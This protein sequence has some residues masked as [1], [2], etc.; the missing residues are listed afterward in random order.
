M[1]DLAEPEDVNW[2]ARRTIRFQAWRDAHEPDLRPE[3]R[4]ERIRPERAGVHR[5]GD[6]FPERIERGE[7]RACRTVMMRGAVV[8]VGSDPDDVA[9]A[10]IADELQKPRDLQ[11]AAERRAIVSV[12]DR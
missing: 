2:L 4:V 5:P 6:E 8:D 10:A 3:C 12:R 1:D 11:L 7:A 9:D